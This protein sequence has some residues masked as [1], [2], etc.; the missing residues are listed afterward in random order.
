MKTFMAK[1]GEVPQGWYVIDATN[2]VV[3]RLA[4]RIANI[5]RGKHRPQ[6]TPHIDTGEF[7]IVVNAEKV[8]FTGR[9]M[10][11][12]SYRWYTHHPGG[13]REVLASDLLESHPERILLSAVRRMMPKNRLGRKQL[14]KLKVYVGPDHP[15]Q[16]QKPQELKW[17]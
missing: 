5:L 8:R 2:Q 15:H 14:K 12:K 3:G 6:F 4:V 11:T 9:K 10:E 17:S 13:L 16:A 7:V 1:K